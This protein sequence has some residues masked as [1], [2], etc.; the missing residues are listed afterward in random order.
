MS[1]SVPGE[2]QFRGLVTRTVASVCKLAC[3]E[4]PQAETFRDEVVSAVGEAFNNAVFHAYRSVSG[5]V[6]LAITYD[7]QA[8]SVDLLDTGSTF[9][10]DDVPAFSGQPQESGMG[11]F[12]IRCF[13]DSVEYC[14]GPPNRLRIVKRFP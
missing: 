2:I 12:I 5:D 14:A 1:L 8:L 7:D 3:P 13:T 9:D 11:L 6:S 10:P 4:N